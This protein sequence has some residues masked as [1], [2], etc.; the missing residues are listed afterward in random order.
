[1][2]N[3][4]SNVLDPLT[5]P[6]SEPL[7]G[8]KQT[9][10][11][12]GGFVFA[13]TP[14]TRLERFLVLGS[15]NGSYYAS[16]RKLT[17]ENIDGLKAA[18][19]EDGARFIKTVV[20][21]S[22]SGRAPKNDPA[23]FALA[24]AVADKRQEVSA[25][26]LSELPKVARIPTHL[27]HFME[28]VSSLR[29]FGRALRTGISD[30]FLS[31]DA[32]KLSYQ[33]S[34]Y[35]ARDGWTN[36]DVLRLCHAHPKSDAHK[37]ILHWAVK[38]WDAVGEVPHDDKALLPIW[39]FEKAKRLKPATDVKELVKLIGEYN[40]PRECVPTEF[41]NSVEVWDALLKKMPMT[42]MI[43]NL[44]KMT[45]IGLVSPN[46]DAAKLVRKNLEDANLLRKARI[47]PIAVL[48]AQ[49]V[50]KAGHGLKGSL[51][52]SPV[53][54]V[55]NALDKAFYA[56]FANAPKTGKRFYIGLDVSGSMGSG[57]VAGTPLT[58]REA[59]AAMAMVTMRKEDDYYIAGFT[60]G[61]GK[62]LHS[63]WGY[64]SGVTKLDLTQ[65][66]T[67]DQATRYT[68]GL[69][70]GGTDCALPMIDALA[71]KI[72]ADVFLV[73]SDNETWQGS[74]H[75]SVALQQYR[76]AMGIDAKLVVMGMVSNGVSIADPSDAGMLDITG[77]D[78]AVPSVISNFVNP[79]ADS[80]IE[81]D[82]L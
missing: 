12:A 82:D 18:L 62:S 2:K 63:S 75:A 49:S 16:E 66:M 64:G 25:L 17:S 45:S 39:A 1:M 32:Q 79:M 51:S 35:Q 57:N 29:G 34:K 15:E 40:L 81:G 9:K 77:F 28:Y 44:G 74:I 78:A 47:H 11:S 73:I 70:F 33:L 72:P 48:L 6:Q 42:A 58:P 3:Y 21:I 59:A 52:W 7:A 53:A 38:G 20:D 71:K 19:A 76:K 22:F 41:L 60:N 69:P 4:I 31:Q 30:W 68:A 27:Y 61:T 56:S 10:N 46:S 14:W 55:L 24:L 37:A 13:V 65:Q 26:A 43:R 50:Y 36:R 5:T 80:T 67:L 8:K 54:P 23:L